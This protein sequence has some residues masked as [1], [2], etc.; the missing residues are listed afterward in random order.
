MMDNTMIFIHTEA[1]RRWLEGLGR[2]GLSEAAALRTAFQPLEMLRSSFPRVGKTSG[3]DLL[4]TR[5]LHDP[6][7]V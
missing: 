5:S 3:N 2:A 6:G 4:D 1:V 7:E